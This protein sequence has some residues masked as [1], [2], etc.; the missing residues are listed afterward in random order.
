MTTNKIVFLVW[1]RQSIRAYG[2]SKHI[3][4][5]LHFLFTSRARHPVLYI[6]TLQ[7]LRKE[8]PSVIICQSPPI[9]CAFVAMVYKYLFAW[10]S[11]PRILID[12]HT[13]AISRPWSKRFSKIIMRAASANIVINEEQQKYLIQNYNIKPAVLEDPIP[14]FADILMSAKKQGGHRIEQKA[15]FNVAVISS[16]AYDE[17]LREVFEAASK[18]PDVYFYITGDKKNADKNLLIKKLDNVIMTG[19][20]DYN[21]YVDL[22]QK[23]DVIMDLTTENTSLV[24]GAYEAAALEKPLITSDWIPLK[25]YFNKGTIYINNSTEEI[26]RAIMLAMTRKEE[27]SEGMRKLKLERTKDWIEKISNLSYLFH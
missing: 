11:K 4:A 24:A 12:A 3:G 16:F 2:I 22:L 26:K 5:S 1:D 17:P 8:R 6:R 20:L 13:G 9:T 25:R 10:M 18:L 15:I 21:C 23:V 7:L 14:D 27:L 19:F